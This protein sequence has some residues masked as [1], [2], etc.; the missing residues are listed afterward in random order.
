M[1]LDPIGAI[2][3]LVVEGIRWFAAVGRHELGDEYLWRGSPGARHGDQESE[4]RGQRRQ[5]H[6]TFFT[7]WLDSHNR[8][9]H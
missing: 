5:R 1:D 8:P 9:F 7:P 4:E 2:A 6:P 3:Q